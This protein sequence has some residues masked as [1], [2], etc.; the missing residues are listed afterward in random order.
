M[1]RKNTTRSALFTSIISLLLCVS[2]LVGTTFA[3]F[4][5]EV[6]TGMN[7]IAAGN[8]DV[9][10]YH[11][12]K[13]DS[14]YV[15]TDTV[16]FNDVTMWEPGV[17]V[18]EN[19]EVENVSNLALKYQ[20][21][22][23][24]ENE[25]KVSVDGVEHGLSEV[26]KVAVVEGGFTGD[27]A[28]AQNLTFDKSLSTFALEGV[29]EGDTTSE[30]YGIVIYWA[31][32]SNDVDNIFNMNNANKGK[33]LSIDLGINLFATQ[34][35]YEFDSFGD[36]YD[37]GLILP[38]LGEDTILVEKDGIQYYYDENGDYVLYLV[39][40][41]Y[42][43]D[44]VNIP[45]GVDAIGNYAF[46]YNSNV[47]TVTVPSTTRDLGRGFDSSSVEKVVIEEGLEVLSSRAFRATAN[48]Q[49]VVI[50]SSVKV[51]E[52][53]AFQKSGIKNIVIPAT[54]ETIG[55]TAFGASLIETVTFMGNTSIQGYAFRGC[56]KLHTVTMYGDDV[57]FIPSTLNGRN[58]CWF[59]NGESNN[60]N[61]SNI[62]FYVA[63][64]TV[65][66]R[67][68]TAM[69]AE[70][71]NTPVYIMGGESQTTFVT[72]KNATELQTA[73][74]AATGTTVISFTADITGNTTV[75][76][77][78]GV[79]VTIDGNEKKYTG[80]MTVVGNADT[81]SLTIENVNFVAAAG[82]TAIIDVPAKYNNGNQNNYVKNVTIDNC[83][84]T[85]PDGDRT[86]VA[87]N[88]S[89]GGKKYW[90][91]KNC[92][93]NNTMHSFLQASNIEDSL[94]IE[95]CTVSSKN[96]VNI[97]YGTVLNMT[98][99]NFD[100]TGYAVRFGVN[101]STVNG[102]FLIKDSTLKSANDDGDAVIIFRGTMTGSTLS[103]DNTT[104]VGT[105]QITGNA[106]V[107]VG[108]KH[109]V[110]TADQ[111]AA[112]VASG[113]TDILLADGEY[114]MPNFGEGK[115]NGVTFTGASR[116][117]VVIKLYNTP[118]GGD[119]CLAGSTATLKNMTIV[120][121]VKDWAG[122]QNAQMLTFDECNFVN[123]L[124]LSGNAIF[125]DCHF[126]VTTNHYNVW[127]YSANSRTYTG[128]FNNCVFDCAGKSIYI[129]GNAT[130]TTTMKFTG[131]TFNDN[132]GGATDKAAIETGT[133]YGA[134]ATYNVVITGCEF[135]GFA[136][137]PN[138]ANTNSTIWANKNSMPADKL[139][140][141][142]D[143]TEVY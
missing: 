97:N 53:N 115:V 114:D 137:N 103:L 117:G 113:K 121:E 44:T 19:F 8:L 36:D 102:N 50:P 49:E 59:C 78:A 120:T 139:N 94:V 39:T 124:F 37:E 15:E 132:D 29:L 9:E 108:G 93:V 83:T 96:G 135:N 125:N 61:T 28:E 101:G 12:D 107:L 30:T 99:C 92:A 25:T 77:K 13:N 3:W 47:K 122:F 60:P 126:E 131:C 65:A 55:E 118:S 41:E 67:V 20:L 119:F 80:V 27:R 85:D 105:P 64:E 2:M 95:G 56:T 46:A 142:I 84:F 42:T 45:E 87:V 79:N 89:S 1:K 88:H 31:P 106:Q 75:T 21:S 11:S 7:T 128:E 91:L 57:T 66:S 134:G 63:N 127:A 48:L 18:Y 17:V 143:G 76:K 112:A 136:I 54:V 86:C 32:N 104:L 26:L 4:T 22:I 23:K 123:N 90:T 133:T 140:I 72:V 138:G 69:G 14:G 6:V 33:T 16:L 73:L 109:Y 5:D 116:D 35:V 58:S 38:E 68:K 100:V 10:L 40:E 81:G 24:F 130:G 62:T 141:T 34:E 110:S 71:N 82:A 111:L 43:G 70:A 51:I 129:D 52:D 74:D 98:G